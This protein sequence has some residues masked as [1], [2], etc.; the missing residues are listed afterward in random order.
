MLCPSTARQ[1]FTSMVAPVVDYASNV[2]MHTCGC[3]AMA[4]L[5]RVQKIGA[6]AIIGAFRTV[7][8]AVAEAEA[9]IRTGAT[10]GKGN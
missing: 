3:K 7:A 6:Q 4:G 5:N 8:T 2:W 9:S 1:L 10:Q